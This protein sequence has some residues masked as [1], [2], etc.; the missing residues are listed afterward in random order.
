M[1][2]SYGHCAYLS[3]SFGGLGLATK[4][5]QGV[6][7][8][9]VTDPTRPRYSTNLT[10]PAM[11]SGPWESLKVNPA[12]G[13]LAAVSGGV[14][15]G[16]LFFDVYDIKDDC[17]NP[18]LLNSLHLGNRGARGLALT[19]PTTVLGHESGWSP[20]G[21]TYW[22]TSSVGGSLTA[23]DVADPVHPRVVYTGLNGLPVN[24]SLSVSNDGNRLYL[25][26]GFPAGFEVL[27]VSDVQRRSPTPLIRLVSRVSWNVGAVG[28]SNTLAT[29]H[30]IP[31]LITVDEYAAEGVR[32]FNLGD[33]RRP[34]LVKHL[35][36]EIQQ[37]Q[38]I[39]ARRADTTGNGVFGYD[40]HYCTVDRYAD[41]TAM[42]CSYFQSGIRV[43]DIR[44]PEQPRELAY[45]NPPAQVGKN[46]QLG[47]SEHASSLVAQTPPPITDA[48]HLNVGN[49]IGQRPLVNLSADYCSS[50][51]RFMGPDQL[52][53]TCQDNGFLALKFT[54]DAYRSANS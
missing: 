33:E 41:P 31:H 22:S 13:L 2:P 46:L 23:I 4:R 15:A 27:D 34:R 24:H 39:D 20:D 26:T 8:I 47:G 44:N 32:I 38:H 48:I 10:S 35:Q 14:Y 49:L 1:N 12:R 37:N 53:V 5:S 30:G 21:K 3:T 40:T 54:N 42:A 7:V 45:F 17:A 43:F 6:Q 19:V 51:P 18:R 50:P 9:D 36:L 25:E 52:W 29:Y 11:L 16:G 28:Q